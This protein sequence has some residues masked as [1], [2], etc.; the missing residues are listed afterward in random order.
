ML[1]EHNLQGSIIVLNAKNAEIP[2][3]AG[4][5]SVDYDVSNFTEEKW[6]NYAESNVEGAFQL[7]KPMTSAVTFRISQKAS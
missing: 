4:R 1:K 6:N 3:I 2:A 5:R 7:I